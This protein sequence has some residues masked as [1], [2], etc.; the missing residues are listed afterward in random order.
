MNKKGNFPD[1]V[2]WLQ[3]GSVV[4]I[5]IVFMLLF[6]SQ[7]N[8]SIQGMD[9]S[10]VPQV[11]KDGQ[12]EFESQSFTG[13]DYFFVFLYVAFVIFSIVSARVIPSTFKFMIIAFFINLFLVL[14]AMVIENVWG[15]M[16][17]NA[18][19]SVVTSQLTF[20]P[21]FMDHLVF[22]ILGYSLLV[23]VALYSKDDSGVGL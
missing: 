3:V 13:F 1:V 6:V 15:A 21:F 22:F 4:A 8:D 11:V 7:W 20:I 18:Y 17:D 12:N 2:E 19:F 5:S 23:G 9:N 14:G 10:T 16:N